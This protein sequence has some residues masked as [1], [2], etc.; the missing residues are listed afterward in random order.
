MNEDL[1]YF[2]GGGWVEGWGKNII[3][4]SPPLMRIEPCD[5]LTPSVES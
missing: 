4:W 1:I 2:W 3:E 5:E